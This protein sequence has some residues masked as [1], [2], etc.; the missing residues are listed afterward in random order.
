MSN[1][2]FRITWLHSGAIKNENHGNFLQRVWKPCSL[3]QN[4]P[5]IDVTALSVHAP[6]AF[7]HSLNCDLLVV[8]QCNI[9]WLWYVIQHRKQANLATLY[10][11]NDDIASLGDWLPA[12]HPLK[13]P[14][15]RQHLLNLAHC[16]DA[17]LF[18]SPELARY[19]EALHP[20]RLVTA[21]WVDP[22]PVIPLEKEGFVIGWG[23][24]TTHRDDLLW[25]A[26]AL[27]KFLNAHP[28]VRFSIMG[29]NDTLSE[30]LNALPTAQVS[31]VP[32]GDETD[33]FSF[34]QSLHVG[35]APLTDTRFNRCR[36]DGKFVQYAINGCASLLSDSPAFSAHHERAILFDS[37][38][39]MY[40]GLVQLYRHR[41]LLNQ[42][43]DK[44]YHWVR[45]HRSPTVVKHHL[46]T[47][48]SM[49]LP[50]QPKTVRDERTPWPEAHR[51]TWWH[52]HSAMNEKHHEQSIALCHALLEKQPDLPQVRWLLIRNLLAAN[53]KEQAL[54]A[55]DTH[56]DNSIW[57][58]EFLALAYAIA[59]P[60]DNGLKESLLEKVQH[61]LKRLQ[62]QGLPKQDLEGHFRRTLEWLP[63]DYFSLFGLIAILQKHHPET[64]ELTALRARAGLIV[65]EASQ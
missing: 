27:A 2:K 4:D 37:P 9:H 49:F 38:E 64:E 30:F 58:D 43:A 19:Y 24:S 50:Q 35:I 56:I 65:P 34:L 28:D 47:I 39:A 16:C 5:L 15:T 40:D 51:K 41:S 52:I 33:Y 11:I 63:Y 8:I 7:E 20:I 60:S 31:H 32:F 44:A 18:S 61:P 23:G 48:F 10:E 25:V 46:Q 22:L 1:Q 14:L 55:T 26:P 13:S 42:L 36:S 54:A 3:W 17:V 62:L 59:P 21:P 57:A 12:T 6:E 45:E 29:C 53:R